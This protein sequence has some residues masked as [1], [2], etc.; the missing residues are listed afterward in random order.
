VG[1]KTSD[2][3]TTKEAA[4]LLRIHPVTLRKKASEWGIPHRRLGSD[5]RF[6]KLKLEEWLQATTAEPLMR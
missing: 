1:E 4:L 2:V 5:F 6:S 3:M